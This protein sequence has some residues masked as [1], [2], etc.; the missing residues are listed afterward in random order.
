[1]TNLSN[2]DTDELLALTKIDL[3]RDDFTSALDKLKVM[4]GRNEIPLD[5]YAMLGRVY[6]SIGLLKRARAAFTTYTEQVPSAVY[7]KFQLGMVEHDM[8]NVLKAQNI[9]EAIIEEHPQYA[10]ALYYKATIHL[11]LEELSEASECLAT[12]VEQCGPQDEYYERAVQQLNQLNI[13]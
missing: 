6:A 5:Y 3:S 7:E 12:I 8:D 2:F 13:Q 10:P 4:N 1:M 11:R 9:W